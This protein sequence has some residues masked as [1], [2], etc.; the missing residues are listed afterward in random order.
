MLKPVVGEKVIGF[1]KGE[2]R[3]F[4][5]VK[6]GRKYFYIVDEEYKKSEHM[7]YKFDL[8]SWAKEDFSNTPITLLTR[9]KEASIY[10]HNIMKFKSVINWKI[11]YGQYK[12]TDDEYIE[13]AN[14]MGLEF[15]HEKSMEQVY[16]DLIKAR[17]KME[18]LEKF[19]L[20]KIKSEFDFVEILKTSN[21]MASE[22][23]NLSSDDY[24]DVEDCETYD[25]VSVDMLDVQIEHFAGDGYGITINGENY[26]T[27][28][29][30]LGLEKE[31]KERQ[32][33]VFIRNTFF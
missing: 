30:V 18:T 5:V 23:H 15:K 4:I 2:Y 10:K 33:E 21:K 1:Q 11:S 14:M 28:N 9:S 19:M 32:V 31:S 25:D 20:D 8:K 12:F 27:L 7:Y 17:T 29:S 24:Y 6:V 22:E 16:T 26:N 13:I 3:E